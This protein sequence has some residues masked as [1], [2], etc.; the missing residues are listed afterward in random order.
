MHALLTVWFCWRIS[1]AGSG[2]WWWEPPWW[3]TWS[4]PRWLPGFG[5]N[6]VS[7]HRSLFHWK[8]RMVTGSN[9]WDRTLTTIPVFPPGSESRLGRLAQGISL[10]QRET[11]LSGRTRRQTE[12]AVYSLLK[13]KPQKTLSLVGEGAWFFF[14]LCMFLRQPWEF[15]SQHWQERWGAA[16]TDRNKHAWAELQVD[17]LKQTH[18]EEMDLT[19]QIYFPCFYQT[20]QI[21]IQRW[22]IMK[23]IV[24]SIK[25]Y[26]NISS[27]HTSC[28]LRLKTL[29]R[30]V[31]RCL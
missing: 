15:L 7:E 4:W 13:K 2:R 6:G 12:H 28:Y 14:Y 3:C 11:D 10:D 21:R 22:I 23:M 26:E 9:V 27:S 30:C 29:F 31:V 24:Y 25:V 1:A 5:S 18:W 17:E 19:M 16:W 8:A 20:L